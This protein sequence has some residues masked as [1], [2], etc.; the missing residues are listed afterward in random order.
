[1]AQSDPLADYCPE[2][3]HC[4][5]ARTPLP[6]DHDAECRVAY[7]MLEYFSWQKLEPLCADWFYHS[8]PK[9]I[10]ANIREIQRDG[11]AKSIEHICEVLYAQGFTG[12]LEREIQYLCDSTPFRGL[13]EAKK[14]VAR[15]RELWVSR[16]VYMWL[17]EEC[18][19]IRAGFKTGAETLESIDRLR[20]EFG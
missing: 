5:R 8:L 12:P 3:P 16:R 18:A 9:M 19:K 11:P 20:K 6:Q 17:D 13:D 10:V 2:C 14:D 4:I 1:M 15:I 7:G